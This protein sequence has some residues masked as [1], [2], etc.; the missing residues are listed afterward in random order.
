MSPIYTKEPSSLLNAAKIL[1]MT[2]WT[3]ANHDHWIFNTQDKT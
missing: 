1:K 2:I 3:R